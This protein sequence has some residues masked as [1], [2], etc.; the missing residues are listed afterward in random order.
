MV[1]NL[2]VITVL[3]NLVLQIHFMTKNCSVL[4]YGKS[5]IYKQIFTRI[6]YYEING[7]KL[8]TSL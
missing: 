6:S 2:A 7:K 1:I 3:V 4:C 5:F 8:K